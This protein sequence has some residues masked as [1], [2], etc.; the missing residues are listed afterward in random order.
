MRIFLTGAGGFA[1]GAV[2]GALARA[3][4]EVT[5][6]LRGPRPNVGAGAVTG[7]LTRP[8]EWRA[9]LDGQDAVIHLA[10]FNPSRLSRA[11]RDEAAMTAVNVDGTAALARAAV[12]AGV[13]RF[14]FASSVRVY[15]NGRD[16]PFS[17][18]DPLL[19]DD[20]YARSKAQAEAVLRDIVDGRE[21]ALAV[22][23]LP[24][25]HGPGRGGWLGLAARL[26]RRGWLLPGAV[27]DAPKSVL[28][29]D[30]LADAV[31]TLMR[32]EAPAVKGI[33]N[34]ADDGVTSLE[35][36]GRLAGQAA[37]HA[38]MHVLPGLP[39]GFLD[40]LPFAGAALAHA[41]RPCVVDTSRFAAAT[42]WVP[43]VTL[44]AGLA[45]SFASLA[46][47]REGASELL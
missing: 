36:I 28:N 43:P 39:A 35:E 7:D 6:L 4:H 19:P 46:R 1:G 8:E 27:A 40:A 10:A 13:A 23:R 38:R 31:A 34:L 30:N 14:V 29:R 12:G 47:R 44:A 16:T 20:P 42:G 41:R 3:G 32:D 5:A 24:V 11:A 25:L 15:G 45:A 22:L 37:G 21:R 2:A 17:E 18:S 33:F 26:G 9:A